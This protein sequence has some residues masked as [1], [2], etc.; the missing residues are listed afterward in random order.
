M[1]ATRKCQ[2][3]LPAFTYHSEELHLGLSQVLEYLNYSSN[4]LL[5]E[6]SLISISSCKFRFPVA[7]FG[8]ADCSQL[9]NCWNLWKLGASR[10]RLQL[11]SLCPQ[12]PS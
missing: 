8:S 10:F 12:C 7:V 9:M 4:F 5:F 3:V 6:Y 1:W 11:A 2:D